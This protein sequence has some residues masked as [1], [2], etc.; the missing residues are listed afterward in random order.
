MKQYGLGAAMVYLG[1][2]T[3][4]LTGC[5]EVDS[6][7]SD[8]EQ[9]A[10]STEALTAAGF[11]MPDAYYGDSTYSGCSSWN[12]KDIV[13]YEPSEPGTYPVFVYVTG[14][15]MSFRGA[16]AMHITAEMAKRG[17]VAATVEYSN[18]SYP[19]CS[20]MRTRASCIFAASSANSAI[21]KLCSRPKADCGQGI[22]VSGFS[23]GA[24]LAALA[25]NYDSR[26]RGAY[27]LGHGNKASII[28]VS[29][30]ANDSA[31]A[32][33][34]SEMRSVN[35]ESDQY[36]GKTASGVRA[37]LQAVTGV[38]CPTSMSCL[39]SSGHGWYIVAANQ[40]SD[41]SADHCYF[42]RGANSGCSTHSGLDANWTVGS[43]P[44]ALP[45]NL[46]WLAARVGH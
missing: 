13:G 26:V 33:L 3:T 1:L 28:D 16:E 23:Q 8:G 19:S 42:F 10:A 24:N 30:C 38:S 21:A 40:V 31:T 36:F 35:G 2:L 27:L 18:G 11:S 9:I 45:S 32:L 44:W 43:A 12:K 41:G 20:K 14:T 7:E 39:Q 37:Q 4:A 5:A 15:S 46:S 25:K 17:F 22:V 34:P 6:S 29:S